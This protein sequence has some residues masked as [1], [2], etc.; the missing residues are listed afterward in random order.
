[1][2]EATDYESRKS[3]THVNIHFVV[4]IWSFGHLSFG[5]NRKR[6]VK[7]IHYYN[8]YIYLFNS[9]EKLV[10][11]IDFDHFDLDQMTKVVFTYIFGE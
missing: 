7:I 4:V 9:E 5:Q 2:A 1:V 3:W 8:K 11:E 10:S 6:K